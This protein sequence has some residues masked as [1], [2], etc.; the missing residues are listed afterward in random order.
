MDSVFISIPLSASDMFISPLAEMV[1][2]LSPLRVISSALICIEPVVTTASFFRL[3]DFSPSL[4]ISTLS[5]P[6]KE[7]VSEK[8][9]DRDRKAINNSAIGLLF[10]IQFSFFYF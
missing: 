2:Q 8:R 1:F 6:E 10:K 3:T 5:P 7:M 9:R 4:I